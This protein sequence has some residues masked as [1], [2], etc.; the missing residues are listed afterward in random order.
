MLIGSEG[1]GC[2]WLI[3]HAL[4]GVPAGWMPVRGLEA[5]TEADWAGRARSHITSCC[6]GNRRNL[7]TVEGNKTLWFMSSAGTTQ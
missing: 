6:Q 1:A 3:R 2:R 7:P 4:A 5:G